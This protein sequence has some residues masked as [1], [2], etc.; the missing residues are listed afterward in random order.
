MKVKLTN[1]RMVF[2]EI[3]KKGV[4]D[5]KETKYQASFLIPK[6][7]TK[8]Y[9]AIIKSIEDVKKSYK[10][11]NIKISNSKL[12]VVDGDDVDSEY[13]TFQ[14]HWVVRASNSQRPTAL[15]RDKTPLQPEDGKVYSGVYVNAI[16]EPWIQDNQFGKRVNANL[17]GIQFSQHGDPLGGAKVA[18][19]DDFDDLGDE[20]F[21]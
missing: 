9:D 15:D 5:G 18:N 6:K 1:V 19:E 8:T 12:F 14:D 11:P 16:I 17:L 10:D 2:P 21:E 13:D 20:D 4:F 7:D 3:F